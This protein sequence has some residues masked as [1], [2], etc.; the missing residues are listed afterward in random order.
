LVKSN[1]SPAYITRV[2]QTFQ[3]TG[4]DLKAVITQIIMDPEARD[5]VGDAN[6]GRLKEPILHIS[7]FL[8]AL[9]GSFSPTTGLTYLF[10]YMSQSVLT[11][12][13]V[14]NWFSPLYRLPTDPTL[15]GPE[16]QIYS[17]T[18][19]TLRGNVMFNMLNNPATDVVID[20]APFQAYGNDMPGLVEKAN[21]T[22]LYGRMPAGMKT[23]IINAATPGWDAKARIEI[24]IYLTILSGQSAVQF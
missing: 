17:P 14:F 1:P 22:F 2:A 3:N 10:D 23:A 7:G 20:L 12:P 24:A 4:G 15:F 11:Q 8:R 13:S 21:Q 5:D 9:N 19:A 18:D 16:F 6:S